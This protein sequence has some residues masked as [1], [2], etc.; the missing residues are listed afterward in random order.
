MYL[1]AEARENYVQYMATRIIYCVSSYNVND[2][3][4]ESVYQEASRKVPAQNI[5][6]VMIMEANG[7]VGNLMITHFSTVI[8]L[9]YK[10][11]LDTADLIFCP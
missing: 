8:G 11:R 3:I 6:A 2:G 7:F 4:T 9:F 1:F 5:E 10:S